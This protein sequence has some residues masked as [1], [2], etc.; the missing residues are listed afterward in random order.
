MNGFL[1]FVCIVWV[2]G[3]RVCGLFIY[4]IYLFIYSSIYL[5]IYLFIHP[6]IDY[7]LGCFV[8]PAVKCMIRGRDRES[9][10]EVKSEASK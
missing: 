7:R 10:Y 5:S 4:L 1:E 6:S 8:Q 9:W 2:L 3:E